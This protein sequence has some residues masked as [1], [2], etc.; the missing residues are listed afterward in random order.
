MVVVYICLVFIAVADSTAAVEYHK[1][2][3]HDFDFFATPG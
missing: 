1:T 3:S 2:S